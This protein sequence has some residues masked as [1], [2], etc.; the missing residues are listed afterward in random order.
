MA[1]RRRTIKVILLVGGR[2]FGRC[3][4]ATQQPTALWSVFGEPALQRV[5]KNLAGQDVTEVVVCSDDDISILRRSVSVPHGISVRFLDED[6]PLGT[7]GCI[8]RAANGDH[9]SL[10]VVMRAA[11]VHPPDIETLVRAHT[12]GQTDLTLVLKSEKERSAETELAD[13]YL[14]EPRAVEQIPEEGFFDIKEG[15]IPTLAHAGKAIHTIHLSHVTGAFRD[16]VEYL[17]AMGGYLY[18]NWNL[19]DDMIRH[20][21][22]R[23][24]NLWVSGSA[25]IDPSA[26]LYGPVVLMS[27]V[28][29]QSGAVVFGPTVIE[30]EVTIGSDSFVENSVFWRGSSTGSSCEIRN[31]IV[32]RGAA[33]ETGSHLEESGLASAAPERKKLVAIEPYQEESPVLRVKRKSQTMKSS[34]EDSYMLKQLALATGFSFLFAGLVLAYWPVLS[35]VW[36]VWLNSAEYS[37]GIVVPFLAA[38]VLWSRRS[39]IYRSKVK[40][41]IWGFAGFVLS[42]AVMIFGIFYMYGWAVRISFILSMAAL[43]LLLFGWSILRKMIPVL[44]FVCL[45]FPFP[46]RVHD[47]LLVPAQRFSMNSAVFCLQSMGIFASTAGSTL[48]IGQTNLSIGE[49]CNGLRMVTAFMVIGALAALLMKRRLWEK[50]LI[51]ASSVPIALL[52]NTARITILALA[53]KMF[54]QD[55]DLYEIF[56]DAAGYAMMPLALAAVIIE[57]WLLSKIVPATRP[58]PVNRRISMM[59][60]ST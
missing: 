41:S 10:W 52:C 21:G 9:E 22:N 39:E 47:L 50:L 20:V 18:D 1:K 3:P 16:R 54:A 19:Q 25:K 6:L 23:V 36:E 35:V 28:N 12:E 38:Y 53:A 44:L 42:Q 49:Q 27:N 58:S 46:Q 37:A 8:R 31:C 59:W 7:A 26:R 45:M 43:V 57:L 40:P 33:A 2:D 5:L 60:E 32:G 11:M 24:G 30:S 48:R 13:I 29:V 4:V 55:A 56:H 14:V 17:A 51:F 34:H 15:L